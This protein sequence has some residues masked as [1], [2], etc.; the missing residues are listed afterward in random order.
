MLFP[1]ESEIEVARD[2]GHPHTLLLNWKPEVA[3]WARIAAGDKRVDAY[4]DEL[5]RHIRRHFTEPFFLTIHHEPENDVREW[6]GSGYTAADYRAMFRYVVRR[7]RARGVTNMVTVMDYMA[8][9]AWDRQPWFA[10]LYPGDDVV[11]WVAFDTYGYSDPDGYGYGDFAEM[12]NRRAHGWPGFYNWATKHFPAKP[13][14]VAEWGVWHSGRDPRHQADLFAS[15]AAEIGR[16]PRIKAL[17][18]FDSPDSEGRSSDVAT[19]PGS[20]AAYRRLGQLPV[21]QVHPV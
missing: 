19:S 9:P 3:S 14:M 6:P 1:T 21:F 8:Y 2:P 15:V 18:Y 4:L 20:L 11:D 16:F 17:C 13:L 10:V 5:A 7:L 12:M